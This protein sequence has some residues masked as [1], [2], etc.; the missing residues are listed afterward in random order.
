MIK[1]RVPFVLGD[2]FYHSCVTKKV[3]WL[4][5]EIMAVDDIYKTMAGWRRAAN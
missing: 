3:M 2:P 5:N 1:D 4:V